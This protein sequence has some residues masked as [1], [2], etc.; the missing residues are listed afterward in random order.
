VLERLVRDAARAAGK[1]ETASAPLGIL[2]A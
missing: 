1:D 2:P